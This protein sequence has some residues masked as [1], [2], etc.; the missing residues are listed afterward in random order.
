[1]D[2]PEDFGRHYLLALAHG[3][4]AIWSK[5]IWTRSLSV[6]DLSTQSGSHG[7]PEETQPP[8]LEPRHSALP[9]LT[10]TSEALAGPGPRA[11]HCQPA[12]QLHSPFP[13]SAR[14]CHPA[15]EHLHSSPWGEEPLHR[16]WEGDGPR[17]KVQSN[18]LDVGSTFLSHDAALDA[19]CMLNRCSWRLCK[20]VARKP[21]QDGH[22]TSISSVRRCTGPTRPGPRAALP[23][24]SSRSCPGAPEVESCMFAGV[25]PNSTSRLH[26]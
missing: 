1:M 19:H 12:Q 22:H 25:Q 15:P 21:C 20:A 4:N 16:V 18:T 17:G 24:S 7:E 11:R 8:Q 23:L 5:G 26:M 9:I 14:P 2:L 10:L 3:L 13:G 6:L